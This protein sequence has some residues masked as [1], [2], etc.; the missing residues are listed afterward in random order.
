MHE[1]NWY[2]IGEQHLAFLHDEIAKLFSQP[3]SINL[4][5]W[6]PDLAD[7]DAYN[8]QAAAPGSGLVL[9]DKHFLRTAQHSR[10]P[11]IEACDLLGPDMELI[12]V[13]RAAKKA[14]ARLVEDQFTLRGDA[15]ADEPEAT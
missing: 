10:G 3:P 15:H 11:G 2:E 4:P 13:K 12:H 14:G 5:P 9:L 6:T 7:E 8:K 1:G